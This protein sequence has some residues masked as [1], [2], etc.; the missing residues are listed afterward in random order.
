MSIFAPFC[1]DD[2][3]LRR[4][5]SWTS[6]AFLNLRLTDITGIVRI[7]AYPDVVLEVLLQANLRI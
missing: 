1:D 5:G 7:R 6:F 3:R 2:D 4:E